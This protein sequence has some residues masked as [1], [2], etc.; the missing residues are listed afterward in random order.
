MKIETGMMLGILYTAVM[1]PLVTCL[2]YKGKL[3]RE[4][5]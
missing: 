1:V 3:N 2:L 4:L 5:G